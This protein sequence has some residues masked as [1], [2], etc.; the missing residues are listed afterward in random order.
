MFR[1]FLFL[2]GGV[3][4]SGRATAGGPPSHHPAA[5]PTDTV[6]VRLPKQAVLTLQV[7]DAAQ[8][9]ELRKYHL[10]SLTTQL[11]GYIAQAEAAAKAGT[12]DRVTM[13]F[14]P[15]KD[16]PGRN[17]PA[18][19]RITAHKQ[20]AGATRVDVDLDQKVTVKA[21]RDAD[22][23]RTF[24]IKLND[25][26]KVRSPADSIR[27]LYGR[28]RHVFRLRFDEGISILANGRANATG[29]VPTLSTF[30]SG[31]F[32]VGFNYEQPL[33]YEQRS[34]LALTFGPEFSFS[35][36]YLTGSNVWGEANGRTTAAPGPADRNIDDAYLWLST[37]NLPLMLEY[38]HLDSKGHRTLLVGAGGFGGYRLY[39][40]TTV[41]YKFPGSDYNHE[42]VT[43]GP[44]H[45][46]DWQYG[47]QGEIGYRFFRFVGRYYL[48]SLFATDQGPQAQVLTVG[49][50]LIGF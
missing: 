16:R 31:Y 49:L 5:R 35:R 45:L 32:N 27:H 47:V 41:N 2:V 20:P 11:A 44:F 33:R 4:L 18:Q 37:L 19:V 10:D 40:S 3:L 39:S 13:E 25:K 34:R 42:D 48:N 8:L 24:D 7:R 6:V 29:G 22:H 1:A 17:L 15:D 9:R 43:S 30:R 12:N 21:G 50:K 14:Y 23:E 36:F 46:N 38:K 26:K 28:D